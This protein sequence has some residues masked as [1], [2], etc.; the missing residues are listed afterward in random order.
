MLLLMMCLFE[1]MNVQFF[2][3]VCV[4][5]VSK[6]SGGNKYECMLL[7]I[8]YE[9]PN[10]HSSVVLLTHVL[11]SLSLLSCV[12]SHEGMMTLEVHF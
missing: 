8:E 1:D 10:V 2:I 6:E 5:E 4:S 3:L 11:L 7:P 9:D 12:K